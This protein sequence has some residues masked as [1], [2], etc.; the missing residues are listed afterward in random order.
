LLDVPGRMFPVEV[1]FTPEPEKDYY[2]AAVK[3][4]VDIHIN[5]EPGDILLFLTGEEEIESACRDIKHE[6]DKKGNKVG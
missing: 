3:A 2:V 5:E 1:F 6:V 4:A